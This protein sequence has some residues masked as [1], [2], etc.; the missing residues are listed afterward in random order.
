[1]LEHMAIS[2]RSNCSLAAE[3]RAMALVW[4]VRGVL[5]LQ[6]CSSMARQERSNP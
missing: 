6:Y 4:G 1:M 3:S 5:A 2:G